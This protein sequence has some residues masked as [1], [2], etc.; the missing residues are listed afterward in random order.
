MAACM[1]P[2]A[3][4]SCRCSDKTVFS[5]FKYGPDWGKL[6]THDD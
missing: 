2:A 1:V 3:R 4:L 5:R 6:V